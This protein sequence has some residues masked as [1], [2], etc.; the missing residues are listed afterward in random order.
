[1]DSLSNNNKPDDCGL[2]S[3]YLDQVLSTAGIL[4]PGRIN[5]QWYVGFSGGIDSTALL[6]ALSKLAGLHKCKLTACH[7]DHRLQAQST[8]WVDHCQRLCQQIDTEFITDRLVINTD[9]KQGLEA[10]A[11]RA[12]Y[13]WFNANLPTGSILFLGH[14]QHD[15]AETVLLN[16][17]RGAGNLG[18]SG[19]PFYRK[20]SNYS[21][22][23]PLLSI[24]KTQLVDYVNRCGFESIEDPSNEDKRFRRNLI[25]HQ[26]LPLLEQTW[27]AIHS[28][29][30]RSAHQQ[31][32]TQTLLD[33]LGAADLKFCEPTTVAKYLGGGA[34]L[35]LNRLKELSLVRQLNCLRFWIAEH[36]CQPL[37]SQRLT[38]LQQQL[39]L[40]DADTWPDLIWSAI[41]F[42]RQHHRL[43]LEIGFVAQSSDRHRWQ[44][45]KPLQIINRGLQLSFE[46]NN[47]LGQQVQL[48]NNLEVG[49]RRGGERCRLPG[50]KHSHSLK[51]LLQQLDIPAWQRDRVPLVYVNDQIGAIVGHQLCQPLCAP[52]GE[53]LCR[54]KAENIG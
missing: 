38:Q 16:L 45:Q 40:S 44:R 51:K 34:S 18:L 4:K 25:R 28:V 5:P 2:S 20:Q 3:Q 39:V 22:V 10:S 19:I 43:Y 29:L 41:G 50:R 52:D 35:D 23:R 49:F 47:Q 13:D 9:S 37:S 54:I 42:Y 36:G 33:E 24:T 53:P 1:M 27:P 14:H 15:Q 32:Q 7:F 26:I 17:F 21:V 8:A 31:A 46:V 48:S 30:A 6:L 12:R 11:R